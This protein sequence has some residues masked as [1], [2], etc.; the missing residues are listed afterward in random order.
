MGG[1]NPQ[2]VK[3]LA[4]GFKPDDIFA[5]ISLAGSYEYVVS[6]VHPEALALFWKMYECV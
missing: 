4:I 1:R 3:H 5:L 2:E 6:F